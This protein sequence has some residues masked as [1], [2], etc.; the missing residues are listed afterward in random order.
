MAGNAAKK[1]TIMKYTIII[2]E[3]KDMPD[4]SNDPSVIAKAEKA[5]ANLKKYGLPKEFQDK[6]QKKE[7]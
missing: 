7:K 4:Y 1:Y 3:K 6:L 5:E 2:R